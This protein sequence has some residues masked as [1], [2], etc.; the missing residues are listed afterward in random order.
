MM[1]LGVISPDAPAPKLVEPKMLPPDAPKEYV[2]RRVKPVEANCIKPVPILDIDPD[3]LPVRS[4]IPLGEVGISDPP[5]HADTNI[6][7]STTNHNETARANLVIL[8]FLDVDGLR[9]GRTL[10]AGLPGPLGAF[11]GIER[12]ATDRERQSQE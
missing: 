11:R 6:P 10:G 1:E 3:H 5:P 2:P 8:V 9:P 12:D 4:R 7:S